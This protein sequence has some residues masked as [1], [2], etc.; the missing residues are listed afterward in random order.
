MSVSTFAKL[1]YVQFTKT[2]VSPRDREP[3]P[4]T[5]TKHKQTQI[6]H[7]FSNSHL[8][9]RFWI[10]FKIEHMWII[11]FNRCS[12][13][14][15]RTLTSHNIT[16]SIV[17]LIALLSFLIRHRHSIAYIAQF[18]EQYWNRRLGLQIDEALLL[19]PSANW[20][21]TIKCTILWNMWNMVK[22]GEILK[23]L[24]G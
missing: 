23:I 24:T 15:F 18:C 13:L 20:C 7:N 5:V 10:V 1:I 2:W 9:S 17:S 16:F 21:C 4:Q 3:Q 11:H 6:T 12:P 22:Y 19:L 8:L 14:S